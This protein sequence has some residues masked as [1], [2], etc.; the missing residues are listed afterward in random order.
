MRNTDVFLREKGIKPSYQRKRIYEYLYE[1]RV[2][3]TVNEVYSGLIKEIPVLSKATVYNTMKLFKD[4]KIVDVLPIE[5]NEARFDL[6]DQ[7]P[8]GH[9]KCVKCGNVYDV[10]ID[11]DME[12]FIKGLKGCVIEE[13]S[14]NFKGICKECNEANGG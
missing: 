9:F 2:H 11:T 3:P 1:N 8:H 10:V 12:D 6:K 7:N 4:K 14:F 5:G 13:Q